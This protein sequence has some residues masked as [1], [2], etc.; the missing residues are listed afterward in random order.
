[1]EEITGMVTELVQNYEVVKGAQVL[2][3]ERNVIGNCP[4]CGAEVIDRQKGWF[5]ANRQ[6]RFVL[7]K[8]NAYFNK[9]GKHLTKQMAEKLLRDRRIRV[10]DC[11]SQ[12]TGKTYNATVLLQL[13][14][15][16]VLCSAWSLRMEAG[17]ER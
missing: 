12:R 11:V 1:M 14:R 9:I 10:K 16:D 7:W 13:R 3:P 6:C 8:D 17:N 4:H 15:M 2:M 5:C